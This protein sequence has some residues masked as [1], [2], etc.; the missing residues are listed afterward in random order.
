MSGIHDE[1]SPAYVRGNGI[2]LSLA[3]PDDTPR[4]FRLVAIAVD[5]GNAEPEGVSLPLEMRVTGPSE[6][7]ALPPKVFRRVAPGEISFRPTEGGTFTVAL[8]EVAHNL[9]VG[10]L[11]IDV[12][13]ESRRPIL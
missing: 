2:V 10:Q 13:G 11:S 4:A 1:L 7:S 6:T 9:F 3:D 12:A 8:Y 5:Y